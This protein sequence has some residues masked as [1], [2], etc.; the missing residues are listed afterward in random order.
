MGTIHSIERYFE[1]HPKS[2]EL[3]ER[4]LTVSR[5]IQHDARSSD[6]FPIFTAHCRGSRKWDVDGNEYID[7]T[8]GHGSLLLGHAHPSLVEAV[9]GQVARGTHY[10]TECEPALAWAEIIT[11]LIPAAE[12]VEFVMTGTEANMLIAQLARAYTGRPRI[13]KFAEHFFGWCDHL[14]VG[15]FAPYEKPIAGHLPP[16]ASDTVSGGTVVIPCNDAAALEK[17]LAREDIAAVFLEGGGAHCGE[18]GMPPDLWHTAR[19]LTR[20]YGTL[21]VIDEV[22]TG[23]RWSPGG[24]QAVVGVTPDLSSLGKMVSGGLPGAAVCGRADVM[25]LLQIRAGDPEWNRYRHVFHPGTWNANPLCAVA[26]LTLLKIAATGEPQ[27]TAEVM[28]KRLVAGF[29]R[30]IEKRGV[31]ACAYNASSAIHLH[32]GPCQKCDRQLCL[33]AGRRMSSEDILALHRHLLLNGVNMLRGTIGWVSA[34]HTERDI[35]HT[36]DAFGAVLD[37]LVEEGVAKAA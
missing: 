30:Q 24:C 13:L 27:K 32:F 6:P 29:N 21:L 28:A 12:K 9:S 4:S 16:I 11:R 7:Y 23:F 14:Q 18:I 22:I 35:D 5:G 2:R 36:V 26:G 37:G 15:V 10:G 3:W 34:V 31:E 19:R 33:D 25:D 8:M 20:E 1:R 17:A